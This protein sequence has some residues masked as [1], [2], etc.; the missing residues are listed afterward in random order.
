MRAD[1]GSS[2]STVNSA[3]YQQ[4][5]DFDPSIFD[6]FA[7]TDLFSMFD[8]AFNLDGFDACLGNTLDPSVPTYF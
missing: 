2:P 7:D 5:Q 3:S 6:G 1:Q 4:M 8:P